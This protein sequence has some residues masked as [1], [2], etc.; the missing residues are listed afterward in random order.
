M[1]G[2]VAQDRSP[3]CLDR[4]LL[5]VIGPFTGTMDPT[6][7]PLTA[8]LVATRL[9]LRSLLFISAFLLFPLTSLGS[10]SLGLQLSFALTNPL[11][12][13]LTALQFVGMFIARLSFLHCL[14]S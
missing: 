12:S 2:V 13:A 11:E 9:G 7:G 1:L 4:Q 6:C 5:G 8:L 14:Y 10:S 3:G